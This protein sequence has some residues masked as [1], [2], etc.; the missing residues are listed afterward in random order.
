MTKQSTSYISTNK[1]LIHNDDHDD[2]SN[3]VQVNKQ[4]S[5]NDVLAFKNNDCKLTNEDF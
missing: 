5:I 4:I 1:N 3:D 2:D